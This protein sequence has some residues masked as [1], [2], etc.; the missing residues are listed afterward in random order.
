[1]DRYAYAKIHARNALATPYLEGA[2]ELGRPATPIYFEAE[3]ESEEAFLRRG[4][5]REQGR[6][7]FVDPVDAC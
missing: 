1:M 5:A 6:L 4:A 7:F 3:S 2:N